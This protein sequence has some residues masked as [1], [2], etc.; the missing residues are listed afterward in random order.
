MDDYREAPI[1]A[2]DRAMLDYAV[3]LTL[4][5]WAVTEAHLGP[6]KEALGSEPLRPSAGG[7]APACRATG[8]I[9]NGCQR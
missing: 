7:T 3:R 1:T 8:E 5:P 9:G 6:L 2:A 4:E